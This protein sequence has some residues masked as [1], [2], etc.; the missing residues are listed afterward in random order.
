M[1]L[2]DKTALITGASGG[3][4]A[5]IARVLHAAGATVALSGTRVEP[6]EAL[7]AELG[8]RAHVLPCNL[9]DMEA[10]DAL[11]K[12]AIEAMGRVDILVNA[13][14]LTDRG[15]LTDASPELFDTLM[16]TNVRAPFFLMQDATRVM[17]DQA[18][19]GR[20]VNIGSTSERAGQPMLCAYSTTKGA[21]ATLT[22]NAG[23]ALMRIIVALITRRRARVA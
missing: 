14:G 16:A 5:E 10:V 6:L 11:P 22:R 4:G 13:A 20:I 9:S 19:D 3:I 21:L 8:E 23:F 1:D 17:I 15:M 2:T 18:I 12:Q 7:A